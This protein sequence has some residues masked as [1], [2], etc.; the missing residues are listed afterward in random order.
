M[1]RWKYRRANAMSMFNLY[2]L[3]KGML[4]YYPGALGDLGTGPDGIWT[5]LCILRC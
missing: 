2:H 1:S 4:P 3:H 5:S